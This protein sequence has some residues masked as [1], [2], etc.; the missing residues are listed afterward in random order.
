MT[1]VFQPWLLNAARHHKTVIEIFLCLL[2]FLVINSFYS[3]AHYHDNNY[4]W[5]L[6]LTVKTINASLMYS[7]ILTVICT[8]TMCQRLLSHSKVEELT[9]VGGH[10]DMAASQVQGGGLRV[11]YKRFLRVALPIFFYNDSIVMWQCTW[12]QKWG[13]SAPF[14]ALP[15]SLIF[16]W[17]YI[18]SILW[19]YSYESKHKLSPSSNILDYAHVLD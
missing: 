17:K 5:L 3:F 9:N 11:R 10:N 12:L 18:F 14:L 8:Q 7:I 1:F 15:T 13:C 19:L 2:F 4:G 16:Y 6:W